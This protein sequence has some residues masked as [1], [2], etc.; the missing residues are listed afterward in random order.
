M[1]A[2]LRTK[3]GSLVPIVMAFRLL[4]DLPDQSVLSVLMPKAWTV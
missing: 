2:E 4:D 1:S 3:S